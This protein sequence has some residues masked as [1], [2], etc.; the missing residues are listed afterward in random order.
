[1]QRQ[2]GWVSQCRKLWKFRKYSIIG[3][4]MFP[5]QFIDKVGVPVILQ[6]QVHAASRRCLRFSSSHELGYDGNGQ[7]L[8]HFAPFFA[9]LRFSGVERQVSVE[10]PSTTKSS[11]SSR[12]G[13]VALTPGV[14]PRCQATSFAQL[15]ASLALVWLLARVDIHMC[16]RRFQ[17]NNNNNHRL[18]IPSVPLLFVSLFTMDLSW[19]PSEECCPA[20]E[21]ATT[22]CCVAA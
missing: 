11:S 12:A 16:Q 5:L 10:E 4:S 19:Q 14:S 15:V 8:A 20:S 3:W 9:L 17:N 18:S 13:G 6:R 1:M 22:A 21:R 7:F 2:A